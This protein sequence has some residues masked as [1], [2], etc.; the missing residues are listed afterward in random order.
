MV[1][2]IIVFVF[3]LTLAGI[4]YLGLRA[5]LDKL[6]PLAGESILFEEKEIAVEEH[7]GPRIKYFGGCLIRVTDQRIVI[8]QRILFMKDKSIIR[9]LISFS[10]ERIHADIKATLKNGY[11]TGETI[12]DRIIFT[13][14]GAL[15]LVAI[16][17]EEWKNIKFRTKSGSDYMRA[18]MG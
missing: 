14:E 8:A 10:T 13:N 9:Y 12:R 4:A 6:A 11:L 17:L 15:T 5:M 2:I 3:V 18:I 1:N 7:G 16:P